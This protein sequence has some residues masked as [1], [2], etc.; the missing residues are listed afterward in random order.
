MNNYL[1]KILSL[2]LSLFIASVI[3][4]RIEN[5]LVVH[6]FNMLLF[7]VYL[8]LMLI[9]KETNYETNYIINAYFLFVCIVLAGSFWSIVPVDTR[10]KSLQL[11]FILLNLFFVYNIINKYNLKKAF[12]NGILLAA[13]VNYIV[14]LGIIEPSYDTYY[15][16]GTLR[17]QGTLGNA[18]SLAIF[19]IISMFA[20]MV[21][22][23]KEKEINRLF[24]Y[25]QYFNMISSTYVIFLT[26]SKKGIIFGSA[27]F[28]LY[29]FISLRKVKNI[30][31]I[32]IMVIVGI[33]I[34]V[35]FVDINDL[36]SS[37]DNIIKRFAALS[38]D[39]ARNDRFGSTAER[40][41]FI[42]KGWMYFTDRPLLGYGTG[43]FAAMEGGTYAHNNYIEVVVSTGIIGLLA[44]YSMH[45]YLIYKS[46]KLPKSNLKYIL[47]FFVLIIM[48]MDIAVVSYYSKFYLL[49]LLFVSILIQEQD[50]TLQVKP[51]EN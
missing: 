24:F 22:L 39:L 29:L 35:Y 5:M 7:I 28:M 49:V 15:R 12:L 40:M 13:F 14:L 43:G 11:F 46:F 38:T 26:V 16:V 37:Y 23:N 32:T 21:Y 18:N 30:F 9:K 31:R 48:M 25:Y 50:N 33:A 6:L 27:F 2:L 8:L 4:F 45:V 36:I 42:E 47:M 1:I 44:Y 41:Y 20:S 51:N 10:G 34:V 17:A 19:M 3:V